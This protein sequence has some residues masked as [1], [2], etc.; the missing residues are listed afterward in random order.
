MKNYKVPL[1]LCP[2]SCQM[3]VCQNVYKAG[4]SKWSRTVN[5]LMS[6][7]NYLFTLLIFLLKFHIMNL[8]DNLW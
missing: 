7:A 6:I 8:G 3:K 4:L 2:F 5:R 1:P